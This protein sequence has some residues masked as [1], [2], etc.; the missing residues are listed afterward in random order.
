MVGILDNKNT[1]ELVI[2]NDDTYVKINP[3]TLATIV[4]DVTS[5]S[6]TVNKTVQEHMDNT[7]IHLTEVDVKQITR[8]TLEVEDVVAGN[9]ITIDR[10]PDSNQIVIS[11]TD[12]NNVGFITASDVIPED[13]SITV[14][15]IRNSDSF[16]IRANIPDTSKFV[17]PRNIK[18]GDNGI[19]IEYD[20]E[21]NDVYI[22]GEGNQF[23]AAEGVEIVNGTLVNT[24][25][26]KEVVI[27]GGTN[28]KVEGTYPEFTINSTDVV[29]VSDWE[30]DTP[31]ILD[32]LVV[33][34][35]TLMRCIEA[36]TSSSVFESDK[37]SIIA[38]WSADRQYF[39][40]TDDTTDQI[41]LKEVI[42]NKEVL[43]VNIGGILQQSLNYELQPDGQTIKFKTALPKDCVVEVLVMSNVVMDTYD[44]KVNINV[45]EANTAYAQ[46]NIVLYNN[47]LYKAL[48]RHISG[49]S[50]DKTK[51]QLICG[52]TRSIKT[53]TATSDV[54]TVTLDNWVSD[55]SLLSIN[56]NGSVLQSSEYSL[57]ETGY[58]ITFTSAI[59]SGSVIEIIVFSSAVVQLPEIPAISGESNYFLATDVSGQKY[60]LKS[61]DETLEIMGLD[62][63]LAFKNNPNSVVTVSPDASEYRYISYADLAGYVHSGQLIEGFE[64]SSP[65]SEHIRL[66]KGATINDAHTAL[67][68]STASILKDI[69]LGFTSGYNR[70]SAVGMDLDE[71]DQPVMRSNLQDNYQ[72]FTSD[73]I[74]D[75]EGWRAMDGLKDSGNGWLVNNTTAMFRLV[76]P[77]EI[78]L[79]GFDFYNTMTGTINHSKEID[80]WVGSEDNV[81]A[82]FTAKNEDY[83]LTH[84]DI[85]DADLSK[86]VGFTIKSS[87]GNCVGA[88]EIR[89]YAV[90]DTYMAR[91][92]TYYVYA[93]ANDSGSVTDFATSI[94]STDEF[95]NHIPSPYTQS[96]LVGTYTLD[97]S[98]NVSYCFPSKELKQDWMDGSINGTVSSGSIE[99][100]L[101]NSD[102]EKPVI[103]LEQFGDDTPVNGYI[104]F[105]QPFSKLLY[106]QANGEKIL[107]KD[108]K[109]FTVD[110]NEQVSWVSK[111]YK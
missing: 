32:D 40:I 99:T 105:P 17:K 68:S 91:N 52:Y 103:V 27:K 33:Y 56:V 22:Y 104:A 101:Y 45:W 20:D 110:T 97:D 93:L 87:Y 100:R 70:G 107:S 14:T 81:V 109:G 73:Y 47:C 31:Y 34:E 85:S 90:S 111:G 64:I 63:L 51:W 37:W 46:D 86:T 89:F 71:W 78:R 54:S 95:A 9:A 88:K 53:I 35:N 10:V 62:T 36:H 83:G 43:I 77:Q 108:T 84:V 44:T 94:Y 1:A 58:K 11:T 12:F 61:V 98:Y 50:W 59:A 38:G 76:C 66:D 72:I 82:T 106:V 39:E 19:N 2:K 24:A 42:P 16:K 102:D 25:P 18:S 8:N 3:E 49:E 30:A 13:D 29:K 15:P 4:G 55:K 28:V 48:E 67:L 75:R 26:D 6:D 92:H 7:K 23:Q 5:S 57:D 41:T 80:V 21:S 69:S 74:T 96:A 60:V 79:T 65:S